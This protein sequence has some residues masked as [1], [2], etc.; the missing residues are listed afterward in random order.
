MTHHDQFG[1]VV[2]DD[3]LLLHLQND[4]RLQGI[5]E[6]NLRLVLKLKPELQFRTGQLREKNYA[7]KSFR[8]GFFAGSFCKCY[9]KHDSDRPRSSNGVNTQEEGS[10]AY[11]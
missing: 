5:G 6:A 7:L 3:A 4:P 8:L 2:E 1:H 10:E 11:A 9:L